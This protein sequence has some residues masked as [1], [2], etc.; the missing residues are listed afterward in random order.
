M[1]TQD[2]TSPRLPIKKTLFDL[3]NEVL[4]Q[5]IE[6]AVPGPPWDGIV[7][8]TLT[9]R[10]LFEVGEDRLRT[11]RRLKREYSTVTL[12]HEDKH[13]LHLLCAILQ[14]EAVAPYVVKIRTDMNYNPLIFTHAQTSCTDDVQLKATARSLRSAIV[15]KLD[16]QSR[17]RGS[18]RQ[19]WRKADITTLILSLLPNLRSLQLSDLLG[20]LHTIKYVQ[21]RLTL[22]KS[23]LSRV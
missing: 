5:I 17:V 6:L 8:L 1:A 4:Q 19:D 7:S 21:F 16:E 10:I 3:P 14:D 15:A 18:Q 2:E 12:S 13:P 23:L 20:S 9:C 22:P 11:H